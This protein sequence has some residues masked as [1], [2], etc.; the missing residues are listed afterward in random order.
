MKLSHLSVKMQLIMLFCVTWVI[1]F[2]WTFGDFF[3]MMI[4]WKYDKQ[5]FF[6]MHEIESF[7]CNNVAHDVILC[8]LGVT[9]VIE[10]TWTF[11]DYF[12][13]MIL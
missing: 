1:L 6:L 10:F 11:G 12:D 13:M 8:N 3:D 2:I 7:I 9:W 5:A 4:L